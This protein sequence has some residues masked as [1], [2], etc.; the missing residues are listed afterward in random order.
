M[1]RRDAVIYAVAGL[2]IWLHGAVAFRLGGKVLFEN[3]PLV[4]VLVAVA[5][6][7][8]VCLAFRATMTWRKGR[9]AD[10][11]TI[12]V[13]MALPG[14][15]GEVA[16]QLVFVWATGLPIAAAPTFAAVILFGNGVLLTYAVMI[17]RRG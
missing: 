14:L 12:A 4:V 2:S 5:V 16:R 10:A 7:A 13:I 6:A 9:P 1:S 3:G 15:F 8:L 11:V 17:T